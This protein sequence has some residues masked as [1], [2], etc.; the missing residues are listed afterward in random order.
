ME[1][2]PPEPVALLIVRAWIEGPERR[3]IARITAT[4]DVVAEPATASV[5][6]S[7]EDLLGAVRAW[8]AGVDPPRDG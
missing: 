3:L 4:H 1:A 7:A 5:V 6:G 8:L 2:S